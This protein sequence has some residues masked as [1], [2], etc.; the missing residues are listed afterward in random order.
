FEGKLIEQV[1]REG[2]VEKENDT[3]KSYLEGMDFKITKK[4]AGNLYQ[5]CHEVKEVLKFEEEIDFYITNSPNINCS[6]YSS[7]EKEHPHKIMINSALIEKF[8]K[9]ELKFVIG[10]EIGHLISR[11]V[12]LIRVIKFVFPGRKEMPLIFQNKINLWHQLSELSADRYGFI[13]SPDL[14]NCIMNFFKLASGLDPNKIDFDI[15][16]YMKEIDKVLDNLKKE[17]FALQTSHPLNPIRIKSIQHFSQSNLYSQIAKG[18]KITE[19]QDLLKKMNELL[20]MM[21]VICHSELDHFRM[22]FIASGGLIMAGIDNQLS[23][24]EVS[25]IIQSLSEFLVF[26]GELFASILKSKDVGKIFQQSCSAILEQ[27]PMERYQMLQYLIEIA[28]VDNVIAES[29]ISFIYEIGEKA[30][31]LSRKEIAQIIGGMIQ[32]RFAPRLFKDN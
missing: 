11:Y 25:H 7:M 8:N 32:S 29:E 15:K 13:A 9:N 19:D 23:S 17:P 27:N 3:L 6:A 10:H 1:I 26:P 22:Q 24:D 31:G 16:E 2:K 4:L 18:D 30:L 21:Q 14:D 28:L 5:L 20:K 12:D